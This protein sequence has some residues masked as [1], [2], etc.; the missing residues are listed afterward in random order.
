MSKTYYEFKDETSSKFWEIAVKGSTVIVRYGK[1]GT[2]GQATVKKLGSATAASAHAAKVT[3]EKVKKGYK[4]KK[5]KGNRINNAKSKAKKAKVIYAAKFQIWIKWGYSTDDVGVEDLPKVFS[6]AKKLWKKKKINEAGQLIAPFLKCIFIPSNVDGDL[7][8]LLRKP[9]YVEVADLQV[10]SVDFA[11]S[12]L[13]KFCAS[14]TLTLPAKEKI[15]KKFVEQWENAN[16]MLHSGVSFKWDIRG[17]DEDLDLYCENH[18]GLGMS[19][20]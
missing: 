18:Q 19:L 15:T 6:D 16:D 1:I 8:K 3:A 5:P 14:A 4:E 2:D 13:P 7:T 9:E 20:A 17:V 10:D 12:N 11:H